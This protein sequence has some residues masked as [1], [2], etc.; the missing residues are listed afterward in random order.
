[1]SN[2]KIRDQIVKNTRNKSN[3]FEKIIP[4][5]LILITLVSVLATIGILVTLITE[6]LE[7][8][9]R[10]PIT[11]FLTSATWQ[12]YVGDGE[13]G[14]WALIMGTLKIVI[15]AVIIAVPIGLGAAIYLSEYA[16]E[17]VRRI[18][19]P[20]LEVL[21][22]IPTVVY[23]FFA[24]NFVNPILQSIYSGFG[25]YNAVSAGIVVGIMIIPMI[26]SLSEDAMSSVPAS[27]REGSLGMGATR[28]ETTIR[29]VI[30]AAFSGIIA[31]FVLAISRAI[32]ETMIVS[33]AAGSTPNASF[34]VTEPLQTMTGFIVQITSGD[35]AFGTNLYYSLFAVGMAL[36]VMTLLMNI[37]AAWFT[38]RYKE[39]Y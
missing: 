18:I 28:L 5:I 1:M 16:T 3:V 21:A 9:S 23:G 15:I 11:E 31:S 36:F 17:K 37:I 25:L 19:K 4:V 26:A 12:P 14:I 8:F 35:A 6:S 2:N 7:F 29:V 10:V 34:D 20:I 24:I 32:G 13:W 39:D 33:I 38:N 30:P 27:M 22:G